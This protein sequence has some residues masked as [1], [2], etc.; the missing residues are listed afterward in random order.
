MEFHYPAD[1]TLV[2]TGKLLS[3]HRPRKRRNK[4]SHGKSL[5]LGLRAPYPGRRLQPRQIHSRRGQGWQRPGR[6]LWHHG[7][8]KIVSQAPR[9]GGCPDSSPRPGPFFSRPKIAVDRPRCHHS[10]AT[11]PGPRR[12]RPWPTAPRNRS[13]TFPMVWPLSLRFARPH[14]DARAD[15]PGLA[16]TRIPLEFRLPQPA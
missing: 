8:G 7:S 10:S 3:H 5:A 16:R 14:A 12:D 11:L 1:W 4:P 15:E 6:G 2:A 9:G 13:P